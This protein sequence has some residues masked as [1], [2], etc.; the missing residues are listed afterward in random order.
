[1]VDHP[2]TPPPDDL[3]DVMTPWGRLPRWK[4]RAMALGEIQQVIN[5]AAAGAKKP[6]PLAADTAIADAVARVKRRQYY[7]DLYQRCDALEARCDALARKDAAKKKAAQALRDA[8]EKFTAPED[9][10]PDRVLN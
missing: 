9:D 10:D 1:M 2:I 5:D 4:A 6:P 7:A 8:E 3:E